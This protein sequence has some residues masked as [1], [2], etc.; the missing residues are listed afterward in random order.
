MDMDTRVISELSPPAPVDQALRRIFHE[1]QDGLRH[2]Y[3]EFTVT[4]EVI[5]QERRRLIL[6][7]GKSYQFVIR[8][9]D[10][11]IRQQS[12]SRLL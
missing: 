6:Q 10:C 9:E 5:S 12:H 8:K 11:A 7:A 1:I 4:C 2:G 3:F